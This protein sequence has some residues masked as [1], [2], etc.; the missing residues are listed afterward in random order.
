MD[1]SAKTTP[2]N[3]NIVELEAIITRG[4]EKIAFVELRK[5]DAG[6]LR[7]LQLRPLV[8]LDVDMVKKLLP[9]ITIPTLF[10][11]EIDALEAGDL[12]QMGMKVMVFL[13]PKA[14]RE[15]LPQ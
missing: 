1:L 11:H 5:P 12:M 9:R 13:M 8:D 2:Q 14:A 4:D 15:S 6:A 7:G 10:P 3:D